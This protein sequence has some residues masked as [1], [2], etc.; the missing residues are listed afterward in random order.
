MN[1]SAIKSGASINATFLVGEAKIAE[2]KNGNEYLRAI[3]R[4]KTGD[5]I[6]AFYFSAP[7]EILAMNFTGKTVDITAKVDEYQ[8]SV[9]L[10]LNSIHPAVEQWDVT[11][12]LPKAEAPVGEMIGELDE[13][14]TG[15]ED[16][17]VAAVIR[18]VLEDPVVAGNLE[19]W[20]AAKS[21]HHAVIGG[22]LQHTLELLKLADVVCDLY[23]EIDR[24]LLVAGCIVHDIGKIIELGV[25][26]G[27]QYTAEGV[28]VGHIVLGDEMVARACCAVDCSTETTMRLRHM[29]LSH[30]G[31]KEWG[32]PVVPSTAEAMA[33]HHLDQVSSQVRQ[34]INAVE[35]S[36][37][38]PDQSG[39]G[40]WDRQWSRNWFVGKRGRDGS[41]DSD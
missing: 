19:R 16:P 3:L 24:D 26:A 41:A 39:A 20:P 36:A 25:G 5:S 6:L 14:V 11:D 28:M 8:G 2:A 27:F 12:S 35:R 15:I 18:A 32:A 31:E 7:P 40:S 4:D 22:L 13:Y 33:L 30:H 21:R 17:E 29:V 38:R 10:K 1:I 34:A 37:K 23:P 9:N